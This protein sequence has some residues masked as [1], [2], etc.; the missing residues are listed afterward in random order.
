M[1]IRTNF[2]FVPIVSKAMSK[3]FVSELNRKPT[4][5][6]LETTIIT[7]T[8]KNVI[9]KNSKLLNSFLNHIIFFI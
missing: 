9:I 7:P 3:Y 8:T 1:Q 5:V 2:F 6:L 4:Q